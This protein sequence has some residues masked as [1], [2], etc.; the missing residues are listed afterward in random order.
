ME[1]QALERL[2]RH[3]A[4]QKLSC[5][6]AAQPSS[7]RD[8]DADYLGP[9]LPPL[10]PAPNGTPYW[11][12]P[13][14][15]VSTYTRPV[16]AP[17]PGFPI[18]GASIPPPPPGF[19]V[20]V[21]PAPSAPPAQFAPPI[22]F[23]AGADGA[24]GKKKEKKEKPKEKKPIEGTPWIRVTTNKGNVFYNNKETKESLWTV[25]D[26]IKEQVEALEKE[27]QEAKEREEREQRE[28]EEAEA[29]AKA[30]SPAS[31]KKRKA[32]DEEE[33]EDEDGAEEQEG[34]PAEEEKGDLDIEIEGAAEGS[35]LP[36]KPE[37]PT[38]PA[39][40]AEA[41]PPKKKKAKTKVV[42]SLEELDDEDWQRQMAAEMAKEAED[43]E[44]QE[45]E[46]AAAAEAEKQE[47]EEQRAPKLEVDQVEAAA[48]YKVRAH[49]LQEYPGDA[50][51]L[52]RAGPAE[53]ERHQS[54]GAIRDRV[55]QVRERPALPL[56]VPLRRLP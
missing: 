34:S 13:L 41:Q 53:R 49:P 5:A 56:C 18:A 23:A 29:K 43:Q 40:A 7:S 38:D 9:S 27:E 21:P 6:N 1:R 32:E 10:E 55:A 35:G 15:N 30:A 8:F 54:D 39:P 31:G 36:S 51:E 28:K 50:D 3:G 44:K 42:T 25:P 33:A 17:P 26:E 19:P 16:P 24:T 4:N 52:S 2:E 14:T 45:Q 11:F 47:V 37:E 22:H 12:N 48:L 20:A 46:A